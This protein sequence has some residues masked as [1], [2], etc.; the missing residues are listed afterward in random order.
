MIKPEPKD[1]N[2]RISLK[3]RIAFVVLSMVTVL[4]ACQPKLQEP[5]LNV[6]KIEKLI[7]SGEIKKAGGVVDSI[8]SSRK[9]LPTQMRQLD[10]LIEM[11]RRIRIDFRLNEQDINA[12]LSK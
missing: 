8:K 10:S 7:H 12:R 6:A 2:Y 5:P 1:M 3:R 4:L 11:G 9:L